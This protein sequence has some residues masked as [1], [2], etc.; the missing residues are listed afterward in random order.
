MVVRM[1]LR[2]LWVT[3]ESLETEERQE[4]LASRENKG[5]RESLVHQD[6]KEKWA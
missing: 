3:S 6:L 2:A 5:R 1:D 4:N